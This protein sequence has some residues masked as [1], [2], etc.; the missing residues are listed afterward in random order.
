MDTHQN[1][2][3]EVVSLRNANRRERHEASFT[4]TS[5]NT[6]GKKNNPVLYDFKKIQFLCAIIVILSVLQFQSQ[7]SRNRCTKQDGEL[8]PTSFTQ[9]EWLPEDSRSISMI[10]FRFLKVILT[11]HLI[12]LYMVP[13]CWNSMPDHTQVNFFRM[14]ELLISRTEIDIVILCRKNMIPFQFE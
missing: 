13:F 7:M 14:L 1:Y 5:S 11:C 4:A 9:L 8:T 2:H 3:V 10:I 12:R 6:P